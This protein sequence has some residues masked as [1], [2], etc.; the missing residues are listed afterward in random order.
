MVSSLIKKLPV[1]VRVLFFAVLVAIT[2]PL[3]LWLIVQFYEWSCATWITCQPMGRSSK[4]DKDTTSAVKAV[5]AAARASAA[6]SG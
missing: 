3:T 2:I 5:Q 6:G 4:D 1:P